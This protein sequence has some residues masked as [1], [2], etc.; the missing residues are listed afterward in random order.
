MCHFYVTIMVIYG[1][2]TSKIE[3]KTQ[4]ANMTATNLRFST[5]HKYR[6]DMDVFWKR[7]FWGPDV[8]TTWRFINLTFCKLH[9]V[10]L[11]FQAFWKRTFWNLT[12]CECTYKGG[13][14]RGALP[15]SATSHN[16]GTFSCEEQKRR[17]WCQSL[18]PLWIL[19]YSTLP[20]IRSAVHCL[21]N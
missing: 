10:N 9:F 14:M 18:Y 4:P 17:D 1:K 3:N 13:R 7:T 6:I 5:Y 12:F 8:L 15:Q 19:S 21:Y 16:G 20:Q 11:R 2:K